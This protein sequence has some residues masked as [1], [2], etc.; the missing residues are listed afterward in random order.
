MARKEGTQRDLPRAS[1]QEAVYGL[2]R[3]R[4]SAQ[5]S[6]Q[7]GHLRM[8]KRQVMGIHQPS[9]AHMDDLL[10]AHVACSYDEN[11]ALCAGSTQKPDELLQERRAFRNER[12]VI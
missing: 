3:G 2:R 12:G 1:L 9:L 10:I 5:K 4:F 11:A 8:G 6:S 7:L